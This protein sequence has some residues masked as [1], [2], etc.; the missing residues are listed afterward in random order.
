[1]LTSKKATSSVA[2]VAGLALALAACGSSTSKAKSTT[3]SVDPSV[4][5]VG[6]AKPDPASGLNGAHGTGT[7]VMGGTLKFLGAGDVD[8]IDPESSYYTVGYTVLR[9]DS[10]QLV[11]YPNSV[12]PAVANVPVPDIATSVPTP[13]NGGKT[14]TFTIKQGV[15]WD[16]TPARQV[17]AADE[18]LGIKRL[19]NPAQ[20]AGAL[21]YYTATIVGMADFCTG[22]GKVSATSAAAMK[23]YMDTHQVAGLKAV[24]ASTVEF[25][26]MAPAGDFMNILSLPFASPAPVESEAYIPASNAEQQHY[27][28]DGPYTITKYV[29]ATSIT[30]ARNPA[31]VRSTDAVRH[32]YV[33]AVSIKEGS[34]EAPVQQALQVG[35][36]DMEFDTGVPTASLPALI[37]AKDPHLVLQ[38]VGTTSYLVFNQLSPHANGALA[39]QGV[40]QALE[41]CLNKAEIV[42]ILG[43]PTLYQ[44]ED[45]ILTPPILG[46]SHI[47][48]YN[49]DNGAED[50]TTGKAKLTAAGYPNG[51]TLTFLYR[52]K[53]KSPQIATIIQ[54][55]M[56]ACGVNLTLKAVAPA[57]FYTKHL[58]DTA[59]TKSGDWDMATPGWNPDWQGNA[60]RSFFVPLLDPR[61]FQE[62]TTNYGDYGSLPGETGVTA[63]I[64]DALSTTDL[65]QVA[66]KW[67]ALDAATMAQAPWIPL[68]TGKSP[69]YYGKNV[70]N[71]V[72]FNFSD[73]GDPSNVWLG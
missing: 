23:T 42:Q 49:N 6:A 38:N 40:R 69:Y 30:L 67:A 39:K 55:N 43:G 68:V 20:P 9:L 2:L 34:D 7:P 50:S 47:D 24:N 31:W 16:T 25:D 66:A 59:A 64:D 5:N 10:R 57:D 53:G 46:Y 71:W 3:G 52:N 45:Q 32:A 58:S 72:F 1:M 22:F 62:G 54:N 36:E 12:D 28:S 51:L 37:A 19:C 65:T 44:P 35:T 33:D 13:T 29:P 8:N 27:I 15:M 26:L 48:P 56:K 14:Y 61:T 70:K 21:N 4:L 73:N 17:T 60:A 11:T 41:Y 18:V 63:A